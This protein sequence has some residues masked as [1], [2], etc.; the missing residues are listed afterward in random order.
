VDAQ[1]I[2]YPEDSKVTGSD[3]ALDAL[4][5]EKISN[6][7]LKEITPLIQQAQDSIW[8]ASDAN[9]QKLTSDLDSVRLIYRD[10]ALE[11][12]V[13]PLVR[14]L[15]LH[16]NAGNIS[17]F[18]PWTDRQ[19]FFQADTALQSYKTIPEIQQ[20]LVKVDSLR[21]L[22][23][24]NEKIKPGTQFPL[25][26]FPNMVG[27]TISSQKFKGIPVYVEIWNPSMPV[28]ARIHASV[29]PILNKYR[30]PEL[31]V[32]MIAVDTATTVWKDAVRMQSLYYQQ[33]V[34]SKGVNSNLFNDLGIIQ[35]PS[36]F[37]IDANGIVVAKNI[38][39]RQLDEGIE[40][41]LR[42]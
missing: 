13:K 28:N 40:L 26:S 9:R 37:L 10:L 38:W 18:E 1:Y 31:E 39:G 25:L 33:V 34:D 21:R 19:Y 4:E 2:N 5:L 14:F 22:H 8:I 29:V 23:F 36:N 3:I 24:L 17:L 16:Q 15:A 7:W 32:Y 35:L 12:S 11:I 30:R 20:F 42:N 27:D 6:K 41:L